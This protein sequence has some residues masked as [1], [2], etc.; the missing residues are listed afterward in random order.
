MR[1][2]DGWDTSSISAARVTPPAFMTALK[3]SICLS[4]SVTA[5]VGFDAGSFF[6]RIAAYH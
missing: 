3:A 6:D 2:T 1:L 4:V 5:S